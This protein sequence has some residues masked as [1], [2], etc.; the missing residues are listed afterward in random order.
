MSGFFRSDRAPLAAPVA[1]TIYEGR[2][3]RVHVPGDALMYTTGPEHRD[4]G[5]VNEIVEQLKG[6]KVY[7][8]HPTV[9]PSANSD[10]K[11][12]GYVESGR[13]DDDSAIARVVITDDETLAAIASG[14]F[15]LSL[16]YACV[17]DENRYQ[18]SIKLD[19]LAV[20]ERAR[21]GASCALRT[22]EAKEVTVKIEIPAELTSKLDEVL[23]AINANP[24]TCA[25]KSHAIP[26]NK[27]EHMSDP[28]TPDLAAEMA[29]LNT[30][31]AEAHAALSK[32]EIEATN[33]RKDAE[34]V[35]AKLADAEKALETAKSEAAEA[36][37][38]VKTD[39]AE[40]L[41]N[42]MQARVDARVNL[43][44][45]AGKVLKDADL[46]KMDDREI[47]CAVIKHV[48]G[49]EVPAEKSM[50]YVTGV[51]EGALKRS[52]KAAE[53]RA[54]VRVAV[55]EM[56]KDGATVLTGIDAERASKEKM[57][58]ESAQAWAK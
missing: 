53:S 4:A 30:K 23:E 36:V 32:L 20:V 51:Y 35:A 39:A 27:E 5:G 41:K 10:Q 2:V 25:C 48:D 42:E 15:E 18:R 47:K 19:H 58:I 14:T 50:D 34:A 24:A 1:A 16:G 45:E 12:V 43:L 13:F 46:S 6:L 44:V 28:T 31:L 8:H 29:A 38:K 54:E 22:D 52:G 33:A 21:C 37:S 40:A 26:H 57:R 9:F 11:V 7:L 56:R 3:A 55:S 49:D 17:L